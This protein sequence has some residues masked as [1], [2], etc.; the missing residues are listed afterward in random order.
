MAAVS[1]GRATAAPAGRLLPILLVLATAVSLAALWA[2]DGNFGI[3][4]APVAAGLAFVALIRA[5]LR[6][7]LHGV[8][9]VGLIV[10]NPI[11][12][13]GQGR[14]KSWLLPPGTFLYETLNKS[15]HLSGLKLTGMQ[16]II[17]MLVAIA[18]LRILSSDRVDGGERTRAAAPF[19]RACLVAMATLL[20]WE[21]YGLARGGSP[22][23]SIFQMQTMFFMPMMAMVFAY[24][25]K[26]TADMRAMLNTFL[27]VGVFRALMCIY[28]YVTV[29]RQAV[30]DGGESGDGSYV[31]THSDSILAAVTIVICI[32]AIYQN[33]GWKAFTRAAL[34]VPVVALGIFLN[35]RRI[36]FVSVGLGL[37]FSYAA[38]MPGFRRRVQRTVLTSVPLGLV[39]MAA[40]WGAHGGWAKPVQTVK[41]VLLQKDTSSATRDIE[42]Y[43]LLQTLKVNPVIG[44]G[45]GHKYVEAV[46]AFDI[47]KIFEAYR[48][49]PHNNFLW[50]W[51]A[52]GVIGFTLYWTHLS[53][54]LFMATRVCLSATSH[55]QALTAM[56]AITAVAAYS[57]QAFGDMGMFSWVGSLM[58]AA[59]LGA[60]ASAAT[61]NGAWLNRSAT[62]VG[63]RPAGAMPPAGPQRAA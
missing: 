5:P 12:R 14:Y 19:L 10:D 32:A 26:T 13:P 23:H 4:L 21:F 39:Y 63:A 38:A 25:F 62:R 42:N 7:W 54:G 6:Y 60:C 17:L 50:L 1:P 34:I 61:A 9:L 55:T 43:N 48:Y 8:L 58:V 56:T 29:F 18:G 31:T 22:P 35:N 49:V 45:F 37:A 20:G 40:G 53:V 24:G 27:T 3:A 46:Q 36:A 47:S 52:L 15:L 57:V 51:G 59:T 2:T 30:K 33:P 28:Y 11:E 41:S 44:S 16:L